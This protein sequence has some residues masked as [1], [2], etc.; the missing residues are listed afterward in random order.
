M[1]GLQKVVFPA[2]GLAVSYYRAYYAV[3][4]DVWFLVSLAL[5]NLPYAVYL[6]GK[7]AR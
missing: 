5:S 4:L 7:D 1:S 3:V 6:R 2:D